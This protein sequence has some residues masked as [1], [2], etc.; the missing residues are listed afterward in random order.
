[1]AE[2]HFPLDKQL[3]RQDRMILELL[4]KDCNVY[5]K[6]LALP[7]EQLAAEDSDDS[8]VK[9]TEFVSPSPEGTV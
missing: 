2:L 7:Q 9:H 8:T 1:M 4:Q 3:T 5:R 6:E